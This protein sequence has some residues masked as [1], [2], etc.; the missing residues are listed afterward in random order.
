MRRF[1]AT[2][3][4]VFSLT[5]ALA[6]P[7]PRAADVLARSKAAMGGQAWDGVRFVR[8]K[9]RIETSGL[10]GTG[11]SF[12]DARTGAHVDAYDLGVFK[13]ASG[14]DGATV[15]EQ[16]ASGQ[17]AIQGADDQRHA[18]ANEAY[19]RSHSFWYA[20]RMSAQI[21]HVGESPD[22]QRKFHVLRIT[23]KGGRPFDMWI[24]AKTFLIDRIAERT[25]RDLR[26]TFFSDYRAIEGKQIAFATRQTNG[27]AKYDTFVKVESVAFE[28]D[29][30]RT[31]F[32]PPAPPKR[33]FGFAGG[34]RST[35][36]PFKLVNNHIYLEVKLNGRPAEFLFDTGGL[37]VITPT[38]ARAMGLKA[39]GAVQTTG[40][41]EASKDAGF[42][43]VDRLE[44]GGAFLDKQTFVVI[45]LESFAE[46]EGKPITGII[47]YEVFKRF[48]VV[49]DY[50]NSR[51]TLVE[52]GGFAYRGPGVR[53]P[54]DLNERTPEVAGEIDG[55]PGKFALDTGSR[56]SLD[57]MAPFVAK[58][59]LIQ[60]YGA[61]YQGV[62]GWGVGGPARSWIV[63]GKRFSM[64]GAVVDAPVVEFSQAAKG[65]FSDAYQSGNVGAG[66]LKQFNIVWNYP[67]HEIFFEKNKNHGER[68]VFDRAGFWVNL[69][70][71]AFDVVDVI[72]GAPADAAGLKT[73]DRIVAV[74][75]KKA[76]SEVT[77]PD[78]RILK[79]APAGTNLIL[80]VLRGAQRLTINITLKDLV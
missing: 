43:T 1:V 37:N 79:K 42:T 74:N 44:V 11:S 32:A 49:L 2:V 26:T 10:K 38:V 27:E 62:T 61:K 77:L 47:G 76:G 18:A 23:P 20:D 14:F 80:E 28:A 16:D 45:A 24:D 71:G 40:S 31:A 8:T 33:D 51:V 59:N 70:D 6:A 9:L 73:G 78:F 69:G 34:A 17:V 53:V 65:S 36:I 5:P 35:T 4:L 56:S 30:P 75:G 64:G 57:L 29:A 63:R 72:A 52:P 25:A 46:V 7:D 54:M 66:V 60:R 12:E 41:G 50:E 21:E 68:D 22:G 15:W 55:I 58:N 3:L 19:R 67:R 39:E 48:V 13:G